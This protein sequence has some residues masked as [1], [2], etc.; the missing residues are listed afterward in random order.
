MEKGWSAAGLLRPLWQNYPG[1]RDALAAA[2]GT[3]PSVLSAINTGR[4]L[5]G[6]GLGQRLADELEVTLLELGAPESLADDRGRTI[7]DRLD[8]LAIDAAETARTLA[9]LQERVSMLEA[10]PSL[11]VDPSTDQADH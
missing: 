4:R 8:E 5:L 1:K 10:R 7:L 11:G 6:R 3:Q 2:V 9:A